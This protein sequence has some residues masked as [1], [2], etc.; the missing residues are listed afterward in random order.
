[1][2]NTSTNRTR[3]SGNEGK[4]FAEQH[5]VKLKVDAV[6]WKTLWR[7]PVNGDYWKEYFPDSELHGGGSPEFVQIREEDAKQEFGPW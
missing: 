5:L 4:T 1:M 2:S 6:N 3:Y 7:D